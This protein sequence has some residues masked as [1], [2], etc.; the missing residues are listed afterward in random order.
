MQSSKLRAA[1]FV[2]LGGISYG[3]IAAI[4]KLAYAQGFTWSQV[5]VSQGFFAVVYFGIIVATQLV[6]RS[7]VVKVGPKQVAKL[8][9]LGCFTCTTAIFYY[10]SLTMLPASIAITLLFQFTWIG[11]VLQVITTRRPPSAS[12][13]AAIVLIFAGTLFASGF[14][15]SSFGGSINFAEFNPLGI[16]CGLISALSCALFLF[17]SGR[18]ETTMPPMQ[19]GFITCCGTLLLGLCVCPSYFTSGVLLQ[20]ILPFGMAL[21]LFG[22]FFPVLL[23]GLGAPHLPAGV[24]TIM[25]SSELPASVVLALILLQ[26]HV[27]ILQIIGIIVILA[28]VIVSQAPNLFPRK[29]PT[30]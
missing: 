25:A 9:L 28:G 23:F 26:E 18:F 14:L 24:S 8:L 5:V 2:F 11:M 3:A 15:S 12:E 13:V 30:Q 16:A 20:G 7:H 29:P 27:D 6:R 22:L 21:G 19:R 1:F 17:F 10:F 4:A